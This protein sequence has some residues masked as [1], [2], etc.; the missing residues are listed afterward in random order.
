MHVVEPQVF[1]IAE[2][3]P[4]PGLFKM[5]EATGASKWVAPPSTPAGLIV[6]VAGRLCYKSFEAGLNPN[7]TKVREGNKEYVGNILKQRHGSVLEHVHTS[8]GL[9]G[10]SRILTHELVRHRAGCAYS[11]ESMRYV[12]LED[13]G[14]YMPD[15]IKHHTDPRV[16]EA[17]EMA[18][19]RAEDS[20]QELVSLTGIEE[21]SDFHAKKELTSAFRRIA[22]GGHTTNIIMTANHRAL[23][24]MLELRTEQSAPPSVEEEIRKVFVEIG[25]Q[26][27]ET[28]P[29]LYQDIVPYY[30][31]DRQMGWTFQYS[32]V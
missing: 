27:K 15:C 1:M 24:H 23:R 6:E 18:V 32:K 19:Q 8:F 11:Q 12:R 5:V 16:P 26:L 29:E 2:S 4:M 10:V 13:V 28:Y 21:M 9:I 17:F 7:V 30:V 22:P 14:I 3:R 31:G 20:Y 25:R